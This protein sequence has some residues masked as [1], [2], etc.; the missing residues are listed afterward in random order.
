M[1]SGELLVSLHCHSSL[2]DGALAP[3]PLAELLAGSGVRYA[4]L[5][6]HDTVAGLAAFRAELTR[7]GVG[8]IDG[9]E[10]S[11]SS[12]WGEIHLLGYGFDPAHGGLLS[13]LEG[14]RRRRP[15][16][17]DFREA[18]RVVHDAGGVVFL[19]HP[20]SYGLPRETLDAAAGE[21]AAAGLDGLEALYPA[22][23]A[24]EVGFLTDLA[25][26]HSLA[27]SAGTDY[28][29]PGMP[30]HPELGLPMGTR[31]WAALRGLLLRGPSRPR[32]RG[33]VH[34]APAAPAHPRLGPGRFAARIVV[35]ASVAI[36]LF[37]LTIFAVMIP[38]FERILLDRKKEMIRE[39]T[40]SAVSMIAE[41]ERDAAAGRATRAQAQQ[42]AAARLRDLR[43][44]AEG[45]DYFWITDMRPTMIMHPYRPEL[46]GTDVSGYTDANGVRVFVE[47]VNAVRE[48]EEGYVEYLWQWK[49]DAHRIVP[50][51][52]FVKRFPAWDWVVG[53]GVYLADVNAEIG[54]VTRSLIWVSALI[55]AALALILLFVAQ[56]SLGIER[57]RLRAEAGV[58]ESHERYRALV[59]ASREGMVVVVGGS[60]A[61]ANGTFLSLLG[62]SEAE[63]SLLGISDL[64]RPYPGSEE[65]ARVF[66]ASLAGGA[67][68]EGEPL[69]CVLA[70]RDWGVVDAVLRASGIAIAGRQGSILT[71]RDV[72]SRPAAEPG[73]GPAGLEALWAAGG[74]ALFRAAWGRRA[75]LLECNP[76]ARRLF[77]SQDGSG[78]LFALA[79]DPRDGERLFVELASAGAVRERDLVLRRA[80][81][82][83]VTACLT[84]VLGRGE[85][86]G[87]RR[88]EG[89]ARDVTAARRAERA[90]RELAAELQASA[91]FL[92]GEVG[93]RA[94]PVPCIGSEAPVRAAAAR[95]GG[96][97]QALLVTG[98]DGAVLGIVTDSDVRERVVA[99]GIDPGRPVREIM[100]APL[101]SVPAGAL[102][103]DAILLMREKGIGCLVVRGPE[104][105][106][107]G[108]VSARDLLE[109]P[110]ASP[111]ALA[112]SARSAGSAEEAGEVRGRLI[113]TV[114]ALAAGGARPRSLTRAITTVSDAIVERLTALAV[115]RLGTPPAPFA[116]LALGSEGREEHTPG[117]DQDNAIIFDLPAG[118]GREAARRYFLSLG[119]L[120]CGWLADMGIPPCDGGAMASNPSWCASAD[121]WE[122]HF[123]RWISTPEPQ[124]I[125]DFNIFF[126]LRCAAGVRGLAEAL[127]ERI[128][129]LIAEEPAFLLHH[130]RDALARR[131]PAVKRGGELD[132]KEALAHVVSFARIYALRHGIAATNT[133]DRL[134]ALRGAG[135]LTPEACEEAARAHAVLLRLRIAS[136]LSGRGNAID[137]STLAP[138]D[139]ALLRDALAEIGMLQK[140][141]GWDFTGAAL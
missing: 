40:N 4:A 113:E 72:S 141:M 119:G 24:E 20:L 38:R 93:E 66:I 23:G 120:V 85:E 118:P 9:V 33:A 76:E 86:G 95:M 60:C 14:A 89:M 82:T 62:Y 127:R 117:S 87:A 18:I 17:P 8:V 27:V 109:L 114:R 53:T 59:E 26:R 102:V 42:A 34:G 100:S 51:L 111:A 112:A 31:E 81:G 138:G 83:L 61:Y 37:T 131:L 92:S 126:D 70:C 50:K 47:F 122:G 128:S 105:K 130:A 104:G 15:G 28:H 106:P 77:G 91:P 88:L 35:P 1:E 140:R 19:A 11:S 16:V 43:Y 71:V 65:E 56:Q 139:E 6:D 73:A 123:S 21:L 2:S 12:P 46:D 39:L 67:A 64:V 52:S 69:E 101:V 10:L 108:V 116:F 63:L 22:H 124:E 133:F 79:A 55:T 90:A 99:A 58:R 129:A 107:A 7:H 110:A 115:E 13:L 57:R 78:D 48:R 135:V 29:G 94:R 32:E 125:L 25:R 97:Q 74:V 44:G 80:D 121:E 36:A 3:E 54:R 45:K 75:P 134:E 136:Q 5:T 96:G 103:S 137:L 98:P 132:S 30:G 84:V 41:Y 49:D 68:A